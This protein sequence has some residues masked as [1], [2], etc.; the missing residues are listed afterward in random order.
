MAARLFF[1]PINSFLESNQKNSIQNIQF[2]NE[3]T[4]K[5]QKLNLDLNIFFPHFTFIIIVFVIDILETKQNK[6]K[7]VSNL[8]IKLSVQTNRAK[9]NREKKK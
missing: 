9:L 5:K 6:T 2:F 7:K 3:R 1:Y 8:V 4:K